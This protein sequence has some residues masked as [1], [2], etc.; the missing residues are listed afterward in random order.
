MSMKTTL[1]EIWKHYPCG[2]NPGSDHGWD[3]LTKNLGTKD[4]TTEVTLMQILESNG[5]R[6][7]IWALRCFEY[8][9]Y[10]LFLADVAASVLHLFE[11]NT[12]YKDNSVR[13]CIHAIHLFQS[14]MIT[15]EELKELARPANGPAEAAYA[16]DAVYTD[17]RACAAAACACAYTAAVVYTDACSAAAVYAADAAADTGKWQEIEALFIKHFGEK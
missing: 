8:I 4:L 13:R 3:K 5:I 7:A 15:V 14:G 12:G 10:C 2:K 6:D 16:A 11:K 17:A 9:N 1:K